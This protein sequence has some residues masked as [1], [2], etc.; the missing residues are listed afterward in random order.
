MKCTRVGLDALLIEVVDAAQ[1]VDLASW[2]RTR[3]DA[4]EVVPGACTVLL[5]G[6]DDVVATRTQ[7]SGWMPG[8]A[9][10]S[11]ERVEIEVAYD[12]ADLGAVALLWECSTEE[13]VNRH[14]S[15][16]FVAAFG[17]FAPGFAYLDGLPAGW[18]VP[19][20]AE[21]RTRVPPGSVALADT[22]CGIYPSASPGGWRLIGRTDAVLWDVDRDPPALLVPGTRVRFVPL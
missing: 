19:R 4:R 2:A 3:I 17:G 20:L 11:G 5:D 1:A 7:L 6:L 21:P 18:A 16:E 8:S 10:S 14:A 22:W 15:V 12:G 13:V 9:M